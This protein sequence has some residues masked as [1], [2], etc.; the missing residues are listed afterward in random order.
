VNFCEVL[1]VMPLYNTRP[2]VRAAVESILNQTYKHFTL[3]VINDGSTDGSEHVVAS[4]ID[5]RV[6]LWEQENRGPGAAMN[7]AIQYALDCHI[8]FL[9]RMDSDDISLPHRLETQIH[10]LEKYPKAAVCSA[11]CHYIDAESEKIIGS[12]TVSTSPDLID[13]EIKHGL[14][15]LIQGTCVFQTE[16]LVEIGGYRSQFI[17]A[18][19]V[20]LFLRLSNH[21]EL[22]NCGEFLYNIR[23][24]K[25]SFSFQNARQNILFQFY[26]LDCARNRFNCKPEC[27]FDS[28]IRSLSG[29]RR[30]R[31]WRE[32]YMLNLWRA[33]IYRTHLPSLLLA[34]LLDPRRVIIR[35]LRELEKRRIQ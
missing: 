15:G 13:W 27:N 14:R 6:I 1:V 9:A 3:L 10:L 12:S 33:H 35:G 26:A 20:D 30:L 17:R 16:A 23:L 5:R 8:P 32:E 19:E 21:H 34:A 4:I 11:N 28:F 29:V 22:R 7:R 31:M 24:R 2:Y 18:E 25:N